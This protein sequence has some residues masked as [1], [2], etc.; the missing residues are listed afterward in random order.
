MVNFRDEE[1]AA[2]ARH[3][4]PPWSTERV[5]PHPDT[6]R[7]YLRRKVDREGFVSPLVDHVRSV[8]D[9][10]DRLGNQAALMGAP[11]P[12]LVYADPAGR[13]ECKPAADTFTGEHLSVLELRVLAA[14]LSTA[15][16]TAT[17]ELIKRTGRNT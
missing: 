16:D 17:R 15:L 11:E 8:L 13:F 3:N 10:L 6:A 9:E 1:D 7:E 2:D 12:G 5:V 4:T 14:H